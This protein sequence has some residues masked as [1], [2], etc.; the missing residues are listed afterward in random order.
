MNNMCKVLNTVKVLG[1]TIELLFK[2]HIDWH[3]QWIQVF[4]EGAFI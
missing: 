3:Y 4:A 2:S 1:R